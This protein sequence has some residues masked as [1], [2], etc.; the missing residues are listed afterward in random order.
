MQKDPTAI[1]SNVTWVKVCLLVNGLTS[2]GYVNRQIWDYITDSDSTT[3]EF[4]IRL[5]RL[6]P[7]TFNPQA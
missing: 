2:Q 7:R 5:A 3:W 1:T 4:Q 6:T